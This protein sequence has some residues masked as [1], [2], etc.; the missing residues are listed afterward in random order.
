MSEISIIGTESQTSMALS[1]VK[2]FPEG[3]IPDGIKGGDTK[4]IWSA[5][6]AGEREAAR[7]MFDSLI[8]QGYTAF[9]VKNGEKQG[10]VR[11]FDPY[12]EQLIMVAP[13]V[14]G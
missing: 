13:V 9:S 7:T 12:A 8:R 10:R 5:D 6:K 2:G 14:G 11:E 3:M 1:K 4:I